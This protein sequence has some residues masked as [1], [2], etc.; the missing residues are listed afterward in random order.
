MAK[1]TIDLGTTP[2]RGDGDPLRTAFRKINE[3]FDELYAGS[4][5]DLSSVSQNI[6]PAADNT[7]DLGSP[8]HQW[9]SLYLTGST[10]YFD[11]IPLSVADDGTL[12]INGEI[13]ATPGGATTWNSVTDKP[14]FAAVATSGNYDD[15]SNKPT[16]PS[17]TGLA[18]EQY[19]N[20]AVGAIVI[21]DVSNFITI[22]DI[23]PIPDV[24]DFITLNQIPPIPA[25]ISDLT[26]NT[27]LLSGGA[28]TGDITFAA[29]TISAPDDTDITIQALDIDSVVRSRISLSPSLGAVSMRAFSNE[30]QAAFD[31]NDWDTATWSS[32]FS[33]GNITIVNALAIYNFL[34]EDLNN[35]TILFSVNGG[36]KQPLSGRGFNFPTNTLSIS[37]EDSPDPDPTTVTQIEFFYTFSSSIGIDYDDSVLISARGS[38]NARIRSERDVRIQA[39]QDIRLEAEE[40]IRID[41]NDRFRLRNNSTTRPIQIITDNDNIAHIWSFE[42][43]GKLIFPEGA[44]KI[45]PAVSDGGGLQIEADVDFEIKVAQTFD[46]GTPEETTE[47]AIWSFDSSGSITFPDDTVQTTAY[48]GSIDI[49]SRIEYTNFETDVEHIAELTDDDFRI[50]LNTQLLDEEQ[51]TWTFS[52]EGTLTFPDGSIQTTASN[53][54][55]L[56]ITEDRITG[57]DPVQFIEIETDWQGNA[58]SRNG[59]ALFVDPET[60]GLDDIEPGWIAIFDGGLTKVV[61]DTYLDGGQGFFVI[62]FDSGSFDY[63]YPVTVASSAEESKVE[64]A[65]GTNVWQFSEGGNLT[66]PAA[67]DD[68]GGSG[69]IFSNSGNNFINLDV[70]FD[71]DILGGMRFGTQT[72]TPVDIWA[73]FNS[74]W[75]FGS[76]GALTIPG[77]IQSENDISI[78]VANDDSTTYAWN[79]GNTGAL[80]LPAGG[81]IDGNTINL[82]VDG[83]NEP[84]IFSSSEFRSPRGIKLYNASESIGSVTW[85]GDDMYIGA[86]VGRNVE[87]STDAVGYTASYSW[88]FGADG[89]LTVPGNIKSTNDI[90]ITVNNE[91]S[92]TYTWN[93]GNTG[94][95]TLPGD[96]VHTDATT[97]YESSVS[98]D[99]NFRVDTQFA[100]MRL[101]GAGDWRIGSNSYNHRIVANDPANDSGIEIQVGYDESSMDS[102]NWHFGTDGTLTAP[103]SITSTDL[104]TGSIEAP[105]NNDLTITT[106]FGGD[107]ETW[108]FSSAGNLTMPGRWTTPDLVL[109]RAN[110]ET[111]LRTPDEGSSLKLLTDNGTYSWTFGADGGLTVPG[112]ITAATNTSLI[113]TGGEN[114]LDGGGSVIINGASNGAGDN[115]VQINQETTGGVWLGKSDGT[116]GDVQTYSRLQ[117]HRGVVENYEAKADATGVV[118]HDCNDGHLFYHT[119]PDANWTVN[120]TNLNSFNGMATNITI[121][122]AQGDPA[123]YPNALQIAGSAQTILWQGGAAP[124]PTASG[125]DVVTFSILFDGS[126]YT[127]LGQ[128][129]DFSAV[130]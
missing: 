27:N 85:R 61:D 76:D 100:S 102:H 89:T 1:Q 54:G 101:D 116:G 29:T 118:E 10:V 77:D 90:S 113:L 124:T 86:N 62:S 87:I 22:N 82:K 119:S 53:F 91:D 38:I 121:I 32:S 11:G 57:R 59:S 74:R 55:N 123:Y 7:Y 58:G 97:G 16:I 52:S 37:T 9:R 117:I 108:T 114:S 3:N 46:T 75:R 67:S 126:N 18:T 20:D 93:F 26:D 73:S 78:T 15:L 72:D 130:A 21:P 35:A 81:K 96:I 56:T 83:L 48:T 129:T 125:V 8:T 66:L 45:N 25:D 6:I 19:V 128:M 5:L 109:G 33:G 44:G 24:T 104:T 60:P 103:G 106:R 51:I 64:I 65:I 23:P 28:D 42:S 14:T 13:A 120:L 47:T 111:Q 63:S 84:F 105:F 31:T 30:D 40:E 88:L 107:T 41:G 17:I 92:S 34:E 112:T 4:E 127:V 12:I 2:N 95:L 50:R 70:Q 71:S 68:F 99:Y 122:I 94:D 49:A 36:A 69:Q 43:D 39:D 80:R 79:F 98:L 115:P 110:D